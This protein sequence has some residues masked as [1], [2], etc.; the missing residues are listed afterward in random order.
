MSKYLVDSL[1][2]LS[3]SVYKFRIKIHIFETV[4]RTLI[5]LAR[6]RDPF[7]KF[8]INLNHII[9]KNTECVKVVIRCRPLSNQETQDGRK[10]VV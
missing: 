7:V 9:M 8:E 5:S 4:E 2:I 10:M 6:K 1:T 3:S